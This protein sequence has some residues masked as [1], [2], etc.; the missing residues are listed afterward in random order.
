MSDIHQRRYGK[1]GIIEFIG[2]LTGLPYAIR[3]DIKNRIITW[4]EEDIETL[5]K[6]KPVPRTTKQKEQGW[7]EQKDPDCPGCNNWFKK[8][9]SGAKGF[10]KVSLGV[11]GVSDEVYNERKKVCLSCEHYNGFGLCNSCGCVLDF[12]TR[13]KSENCPVLKWTALTVSR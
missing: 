8:L 9:A 5:M 11:D 12:K 7:R 1:N 10:I 3:V 4:L 6:P 13:I 2:S